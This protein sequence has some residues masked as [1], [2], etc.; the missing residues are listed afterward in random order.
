MGDLGKH[1]WNREHGFFPFFKNRW[2]FNTYINNTF[3]HIFSRWKYRNTNWIY[4]G[5]VVLWHTIHSWAR[6]WK[7]IKSHGIV[8]ESV[9]CKVIIS[10]GSTK[11]QG[12]CIFSNSLQRTSRPLQF[13]LILS[14]LHENWRTCFIQE[15]N[16]QN[17]EIQ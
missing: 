16:K 3:W 5:C 9:F 14:S 1:R 7:N 4:W 10:K 12:N 13:E 8:T 6:I 15:R 17:K 11:P 2:Q